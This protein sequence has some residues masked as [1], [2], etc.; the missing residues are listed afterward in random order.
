MWKHPST[1]NLSLGGGKVV[2][3]HTGDPEG[4]H[5]SPCR[6]DAEGP[7]SPDSAHSSFVTLRPREAPRLSL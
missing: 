3:L 5:T 7:G 6:L 2:A 4:H 1:Q